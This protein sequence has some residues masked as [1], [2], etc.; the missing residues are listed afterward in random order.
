[1]AKVTGIG[2][3]FFKSQD[4]AKLKAWYQQHLGIQPDGEG[5]VSFQWREKDDPDHIGATVW[6]A[7]KHDTDYFEP[8]QKPFMINFRVDDLDGL[9][10][11]LRAAGCEV[12]DKVESYEYGRFGWIMDPEGHRIELWEP[13]ARDPLA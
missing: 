3:I 13:P 6:E 9:L 11:K 10:S 5:Y 4:P 12:D 7:C 8:S 2:G 1:M